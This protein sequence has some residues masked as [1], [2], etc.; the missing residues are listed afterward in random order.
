MVTTSDIVY[1]FLISIITVIMLKGYERMNNKEYETD[2]YIKV[3]LI[4]LLSSIATFYIKTLINPM[5]GKMLG[6]GSTAQVI[7]QSISGGSTPLS[8][9]SSIPNLATMDFATM[10][11]K[12]KTG[13]P[14]F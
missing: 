7:N 6:G 3:F 13:T 12:F 8:T 1:A 11:N 14:T 9:P 10:H 4:T 5:L 2:E